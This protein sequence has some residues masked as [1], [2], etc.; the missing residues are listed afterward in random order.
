MDDMYWMSQGHD[1]MAVGAKHEAKCPR[2][3][4]V[5]ES[6]A[7]RISG[8]FMCTVRGLTANLGAIVGVTN[9]VHQ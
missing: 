8:W 3:N 6:A 1:R 4:G 5:P 9:P 2:S 7:K